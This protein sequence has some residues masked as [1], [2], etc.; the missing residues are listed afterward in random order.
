M[1]IL[2][3]VRS[4]PGCSERGNKGG[5]L[6]RY[7]FVLCFFLQSI[8]AYSQFFVGQTKDF[9]NSFL[10]KNHIKFTR[11]NLTDTTSRL[12]WMNENQYQVILVF[13]VKDSVILQT[14]IPENDKVINQLVRKFTKD[15]VTVSETEWRNYAKGKIYQIRLSYLLENALF[16]ISIIPN[17]E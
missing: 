15:F 1:A 14:I 2:S 8:S 9:A 17:P 3:K 4:T 5:S 12:S 7:A 13:D 16:T 11:A 10:Q 6:K